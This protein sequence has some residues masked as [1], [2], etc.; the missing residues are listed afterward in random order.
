MKAKRNSL[1][2]FEKPDPSFQEC[3]DV[4]CTV[5][6]PT[7]WSMR[8]ILLILG[9]FLISPWIFMMTKKNTLTGISTKVNDFYDGYFSCACPANSTCTQEAEPTPTKNEK[10]KT[11]L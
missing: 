6:I 2:R 1:G 7:G 8:F 5:R 4:E 10:N 9:F 3:Q 11:S